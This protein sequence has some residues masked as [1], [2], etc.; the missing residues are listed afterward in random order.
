MRQG[1]NSFGSWLDGQ[2]ISC[3]AVGQSNQVCPVYGQMSGQC[4][5]CT[6]AMRSE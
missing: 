6:C 3:E 1:A 2:N 4:S 5:V